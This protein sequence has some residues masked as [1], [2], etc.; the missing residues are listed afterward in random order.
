[1]AQFTGKAA[2]TAGPIA[3]QR[4]PDTFDTEEIKYSNTQACNTSI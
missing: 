1:M 2:A 4:P 3:Q